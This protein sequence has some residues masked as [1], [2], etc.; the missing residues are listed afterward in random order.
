MKLRGL[1]ID[2]FTLLLEHSEETDTQR[3][4]GTTLQNNSLTSK[5]YTRSRKDL[6]S[7]N[8][9][10]RGVTVGVWLQVSSRLG[11]RIIKWAD[12]TELGFAFVKGNGRTVI[13]KSTVYRWFQS[14]NF[15][16]VMVKGL[17]LLRIST[18]RKL[19]SLWLSSLIE[20]WRSFRNQSYFSRSTFLGFI[21]YSQ[22]QQMFFFVFNIDYHK[23]RSSAKE[24]RKPMTIF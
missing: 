7:I 22:N 21:L 11:T 13:P 4:R 24:C 6:I 9:D 16:I 5:Y 14:H 19:A 10:P 15:Y 18:K 3:R 2:L 23:N 8:N 20:I 12:S 1:N 17:I